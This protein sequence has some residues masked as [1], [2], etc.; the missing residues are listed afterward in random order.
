MSEYVIVPDGQG[1]TVTCPHC[2]I[3]F[4]IRQKKGGG[5]YYAKNIK[6]LTTV[7]LLIVKW[8]YDNCQ[9]EWLTRSEG[10]KS[11]T[12]YAREH[13]EKYVQDEMS[14]ILRYRMVS[15]VARF[16][17]MVGMGLFYMTKDIRELKDEDTVTIRNLR[18]PRY[19]LNVEM[20]KQ[21]I[22]MKGEI[23]R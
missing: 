3:P 5:T 7:A 10:Y 18:T 15:F 8:W 11:F 12:N 23:P 20:A 21:V 1:R 17:E 13:Q 4:D 2:Q 22:D 9:N 19:K 6:K 14:R 16:S